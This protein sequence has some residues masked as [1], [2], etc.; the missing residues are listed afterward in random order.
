MEVVIAG[1][2]ASGGLYSYTSSVTGLAWLVRLFGVAI[3]MLV[4][5]RE[6]I[7][8]EPEIQ[9]RTGPHQAHSISG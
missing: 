2:S 9:K 7:R 8:A 1:G 6:Q 3:P 5:K 4:V